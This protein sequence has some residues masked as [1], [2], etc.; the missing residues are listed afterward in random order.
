MQY[1]RHL[2]WRA[3]ARHLDRNA[4]S[5][6]TRY[7]SLNC[8]ASNQR[9]IYK[10]QIVRLRK[11]MHCWK[12]QKTHDMVSR[13]APVCEHTPMW[14]AEGCKPVCYHSDQPCSACH[15]AKQR[16]AMPGPPN[17]VWGGFV[18]PL[19]V[20][21][22]VLGMAAVWRRAKGNQRERNRH[23]Y[24][25]SSERR[26]PKSLEGSSIPVIDVLTNHDWKQCLKP[27]IKP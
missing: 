23:A 8:L 6:A 12:L 19:N 10:A 14:G 16:R 21:I 15:P 13:S 3:P 4:G 25:T 20:E 24:T 9:R 5:V 1:I 26:G 7:I 18:L 22:F 11:G 2:T 27:D 17:P